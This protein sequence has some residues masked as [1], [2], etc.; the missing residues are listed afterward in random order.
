[1][2]KAVES[3][4]KNRSVYSD[5]LQETYKDGEPR[6]MADIAA[7]AKSW[8]KSADKRH[9]E[10]KRVPLQKQLENVQKALYGKQERTAAPVKDPSE[11]SKMSDQMLKRVLKGY[12]SR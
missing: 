6:L 9:E 1:M 8:A 2:A 12:K 11:K 4:K 3:M 7:D 10:S 5:V